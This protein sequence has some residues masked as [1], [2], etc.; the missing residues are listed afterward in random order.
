MH[1]FNILG[2][3]YCLDTYT[4]KAFIMAF[5]G[6]CFFSAYMFIILQV[7]TKA[8]RLPVQACNLVHYHNVYQCKT[9]SYTRFVFL[10]SM[11]ATIACICGILPC[12]MPYKT[13]DTNISSPVNSFCHTP[14]VVRCLS[15]IF[16]F[17]VLCVHHKLP[18]IIRIY[19]I[20]NWCTCLSCS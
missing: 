14:D 20:H 10:A 1:Y 7:T 8:Y 2:L 6:L 13:I 4:F 19:Q 5:I 15:F 18:E 16:C 12:N 3:H 11:V 17:S 9:L